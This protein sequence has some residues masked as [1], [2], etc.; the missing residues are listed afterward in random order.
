MMLYVM[1][2]NKR[3]CSTMP[4]SLKYLALAGT[5]TLILNAA[6]AWAV[7]PAHWSI[8]EQVNRTDSSKSWVS[9]TAIDLGKMIWQYD[10]EIT[11]VTGTVNVPILGDITQDI[12]SSIP[13]ESRVGSGTSRNLPAIILDDTISDPASGTTAD[14][15]V[16][17]DSAGFGRAL[18][19]NIMLG[20]VNVPLFGSRPIQRVNVEASIDVIGYDFGDYNRDGQVNAAD[21]VVWRDSFGATGPD[22]MAD[23]DGD[24]EIT[25]DDLAIWRSHFAPAG[26]SSLSQGELI[27]EP[28]SVSLFLMAVAAILACSQRRGR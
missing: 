1:T 26:G 16:E 19:T 12:T 17:V 3:G 6:P 14:L 28:A 8:V 18:F 2:G 7:N 11:K 25:A 20:S 21:Y 27:P 15:N 5:I 10:F 9:P 23:G 4:Y 13:P 22:L 24:M